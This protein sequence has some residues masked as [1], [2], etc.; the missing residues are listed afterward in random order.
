MARNMATERNRTY[1]F[2]ERVGV[3]TGV[4]NVAASTSSRRVLT[5]PTLISP[6]PGSAAIAVAMP[7]ASAIAV[8]SS[9]AD[10]VT[11]INAVSGKTVIRNVCTALGISYPVMV[12]ST[13]MTDG[14]IMR[15][16]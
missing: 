1:V 4:A 5:G 3:I 12:V 9:L 10:A 15:V 16:R 13:V 14:P 2:I 11:R 7:F 8:S 6:S